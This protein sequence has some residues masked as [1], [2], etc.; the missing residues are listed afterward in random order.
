MNQPLDASA[1]D[2]FQTGGSLAADAP[3]Y[4]KR[5]ADDELYAAI[6]KGEFCYV[7][8]SRQMGKSSLRVQIM[9]RLQ[10]EGVACAA[11]D[12][13]RIGSQQVEASRWYAGLI[14]SLVS[15]FELPETFNLRSWLQEHEYL[16][17]VQQLGEFIES[18]LLVQ[19]EQPVVIFVDEIDSVLSLKFP[20]DDLFTFIRAC[21]NQRVDNAAYGRLTFVLLGVATPADLVRDKTRTPFNVGKAIELSGLQFDRA[22]PLVEALSQKL[23]NPAEVLQ[24]ILGWTEGQPFLTQKLCRLVVEQSEAGAGLSNEMVDCLVKTKVID[25]WET[26]DDQDHL[27]TIQARILQDE[28]KAGRRLGIYQQVLQQGAVPY[29]GSPEQMELRLSGLVVTHRGQLEV[30][31]QVYARVFNAEWVN[32]ALGR[33]RPYAEAITAWLA[34]EQQ[35]DSRLLQGQALIDAQGWALGKNLGTQDYEFLAASREL[36]LGKVKA[37]LVTQEKANQIL[38]EANQKAARRL[39]LSAGGVV[40]ALSFALIASGWGWSTLNWAKKSSELERRGTALLKYQPE[41]YT[42]I[43]V[44]LAA[45]QHGQDLRDFLKPR[46]KILNED[47]TNSPAFALVKSVN[48]VI[49]VNKIRG[50]NVIFFEDENQIFSAS[51]SEDISYSYDQNGKEN[52][53]VKGGNNIRFLLSKKRILAASFRENMSYVYDRSG[54]ELFRLKGGGEIGV[55]KD[56]EVIVT[57][58]FN[59][60]IIYVYDQNGKELFQLK[61]GSGIAISAD[62]QRIVATSYDENLSYVY[63]QNGKELFQLKGGSGIAISADG[64]RIVA[65]SY[66]ENLSYVYDQ[67]GK[68]LFQLKGGSGIAISADRQRIIAASYDENLSYVYEQNGKELFQL[69]GGSDIAISADGQSIV[70]NSNDE[71]LSYVYN[72]EGQEIFQLKGGSSSV[73]SS[74]GQRVITSSYDENSSY[75]YD[76]KAGLPRLKG[77]NARISEDEKYIFAESEKDKLIYV[78]DQN[79]QLLFH[80]QGNRFLSNIKETRRIIVGSYEDDLSYVYDQS[81]QKLFQLQGGLF[82]F[83]SEDGQHILTNSYKSNVGYLYDQKGV[84]LSKIEGFILSSS[85]D[86]KQILSY[87]ADK[88]RIFMHNQAGKQLLSLDGERYAILSRDE[89]RIFTAAT[90]E[91][92]LINIYDQDGKK[93]FQIKGDFAMPSE[94]GHRI[95]AEIYTE[96]M[97]YVYD[98]NGRELFQLKGVFSDP[99][100]ELFLPPGE[101][102]ERIFT[103]SHTDSVSYVY[104]QNGKELFQLNGTH[105]RLS[106]DGQIIVTGSRKDAATR[107][108]DLNGNLLAEFPGYEPEFLGNDRLIFKS[109]VDDSLEIWPIE[110]ELDDLLARGCYWLRHYFVS[111]PEEK[112]EVCSQL[113][114]TP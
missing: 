30:Y 38:E 32:Q 98:Q 82:A 45:I 25:H 94:N 51:F 100:G 37:A 113:A 60:N 5:D 96:N 26:Q 103:Q 50:D 80:L 33:L 75:I 27:R 105:L 31:N 64:Q 1:A 10:A 72:K 9:Q 12:I 79:G 106:K 49:E 87:D 74:D 57:A 76:L 43:D 15:G 107:L 42:E 55:S 62:G 95:F 14:R 101:G 19:I 89:K 70:A 48:N 63:D 91:D 54:K 56:E 39:K 59:D 85:E 23:A 40:F 109:T 68:E 108:Y 46:A 11:I 66:D 8:N 88:D 99:S 93:L 41:R 78:H 52:F 104:D 97:S 114:S 16:T 110:Y 24:C 6:K 65:T 34:S 7:L 112:P 20:T 13:T 2:L 21:Y 18:V 84:E 90:A 36:D 58:S 22:Q 35:D 83:T 61:G 47:I 67:N 28:R 29:D 4:V 71:N 3:T 92:G 44:L 53:R 102:G 86:M 111:H 77:S 17:P 81:G 69:K 73:I